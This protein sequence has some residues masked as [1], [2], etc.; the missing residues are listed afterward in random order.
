MNPLNRM[1]PGAVTTCNCEP[2]DGTLTCNG[3]HT[4]RDFA[5]DLDDT[6]TIIQPGDTQNAVSAYPPKLAANSL[7]GKRDQAYTGNGYGAEVSHVSGEPTSIPEYVESIVIRA[8]DLNR[9][10]GGVAKFKV[11][12]PIVREIIARMEG[13]LQQLRT[14]VKD[15]EQAER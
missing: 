8:G 13:D 10:V 11:D 4:E 2:V 12:G 15:I 14:L 7:Y 6:L 9:W 1:N 5:R 3:H